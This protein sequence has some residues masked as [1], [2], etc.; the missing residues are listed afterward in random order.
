M[1]K[2]V[3]L[4]SLVA[5]NVAR[6]TDTYCGIRALTQ[7]DSIAKLPA[8]YPNNSYLNVRQLYSL[9]YGLVTSPILACQKCLTNQYNN[10]E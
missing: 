10:L 7:W 9:G 6:R 3:E 2:Q 8:T 4:A 1:N 5:G